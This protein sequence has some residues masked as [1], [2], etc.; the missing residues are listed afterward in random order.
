MN[1]DENNTVDE[2]FD[3]GE[4]VEIYSRKAVWWFSFFSPIIGGIMLAINLYN[5]GYKKA[6]AGVVIFSILFYM[7]TNLIGLKLAEY[8]E[9]N[10]SKIDLKN[11][12]IATQENFVKFT[13][14]LVALNILGATI[15]TRFFFK[16]YFP[17][18]DYYPRSIMGPLV[19]MLVIIFL[20]FM[21][22][23]I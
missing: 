8:Y 6:I 7:A 13:L 23:G 12:D 5:V 20:G 4:P 9:I 15:T 11:I 16:R 19:V 21:G 10:M 2:Q 22:A 3:G 17:E 14:I 1:F 18:D